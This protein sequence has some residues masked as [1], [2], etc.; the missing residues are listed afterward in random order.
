MRTGLAHVFGKTQEKEV[1]ESFLCSVCRSRR[2]ER[3]GFGS[4]AMTAFATLTITQHT[5]HNLGTDCM[6]AAPLRSIDSRR[7]VP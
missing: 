6:T 4:A 7:S 5:E 2:L 1:L 3:N